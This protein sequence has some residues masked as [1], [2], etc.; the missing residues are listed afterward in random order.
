[1]NGDDLKRKMSPKELDFWARYAEKLMEMGIKSPYSGWY[2]ARA[3]EF[4]YQLNGRKLKAVDSAYLDRYFAE[5]GRKAELQDWQLLQ[6]VCAVEIL[7]CEMTGLSWCRSYDWFGQKMACREIGEAHPTRARDVAPDIDFGGRSEH[8]ELG[9]EALQTLERIKALTRTRGMSIRTEQTYVEWAQRF[10]SFCDGRFP[11]TGEDIPVYM[12]YLALVRRVAPSTQAQALNALVF[13]YGQ[14]LE[15]E[16]GDFGNYRRPARKQRFPEVL[17]RSEVAALLGAMTGRQAIMAG[18]LYGA[19]LRLMECI[20]LR[21]KDIDFD[22]HYITVVEGKGGKDRRVP[23]PDQLV[24]KLREH[25]SEVRRI[26][27]ADL[28]AGLA[29]VYLPEGISRK[30]PNAGKEWAW[31]YVFPSTRISEDPRTGIRRRHHIHENNLQKAVKKSAAEVGISKRVGCHTLR[32]SFAT[33]LLEGGAD[34][35]TVQEL[36]GHSDVSTTMIYTHVM[37]RPGLTVRSPLDLL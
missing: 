29:G 13:V 6:T 22:N 9:K 1:M 2:V 15:I 8:A 35:R 18:L 4:V 30:V 36:L 23:L 3:Q 5:L 11:V 25:L 32:H 28:T 7:M 27:E 31:Q 24:P 10:A 34:I 19:G 12:E 33:H 16:L 17:S 21:V 26:Y 37:N 20:R 14:V